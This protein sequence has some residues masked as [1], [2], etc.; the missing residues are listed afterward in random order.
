MIGG[1]RILVVDDH[2]IVRQGLRS[3]LEKESGIEV[4]GEAFDGTSA[5][6]AAQELRPDVIIMD[7]TMAGMNGIEA[8][9]RIIALMPTARILCLSLHAD[10]HIVSSMLEAG[11][12]GYV[13][14]SADLTELAAAVRAVAFGQIFL[15][16]TIAGDFVRDHL[17]HR[18]SMPAEPRLT[19]REREVLQL[20]AEGNGTGEIA[21]RLFISAKTVSTHRENIMRKLNLHNV[22]AL[23]KY[24]IRQG[25]SSIEP[26][27]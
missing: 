6:A 24:A 4:I 1:I 21:G 26:D 11:A 17:A 27:L 9:R 13:V 8:T 10:P 16:P 19:D 7:V 3:L 22:V 12:S 2:S 20:I 18:A 14:K 15:S 23:T 25:I 5:V